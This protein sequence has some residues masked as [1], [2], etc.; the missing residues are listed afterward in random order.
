MSLSARAARCENTGKANCLIRSGQVSE[1]PILDAVRMAS[2]RTSG[3]LSRSN[4]NNVK[5][6]REL[7][8]DTINL[9]A[10]ARSA[11]FGDLLNFIKLAEE[12]ERR[13]LWRDCVSAWSAKMRNSFREDRKSVV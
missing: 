11:V 6:V 1:R 2:I 5:M 8:E 3:A 13:S 7:S 12:T 9:A 10:K 4:S